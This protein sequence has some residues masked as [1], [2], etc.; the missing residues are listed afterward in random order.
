MVNRYKISLLGALLMF[1]CLV[2]PAQKKQGYHAINSGIPWFDGKGNAISAHGANIIMDKGRYY[3]FGEYKSDTSNAFNGFSC[4]SS[5]DLCN[6]KFENMAL[7][8]QDTGKLG[9][10]RVGERVKILKCPATG[11]YVMFMHADDMGYKDQ[12]IG[13]ATCNTINGTYKFRGPLL[14]DGK[15]IKKWDMGVFQ[16]TDGSGYVIT[17]SGNLYKLSGDYKSVT[18][19]VVKDMTQQCEAP[20]IFK[21]SGVYFWLGSDLTSWE[22]NDNYYFTAT[23]LKGPWTP[24]GN[25]A[26]RGTLT[27]NSQT[28]YVLTIAGAEDTTYMYMGDRWAFPHQNS[29]ATYV[30]QPLIVKGTTLSLPGF[31]Q[32]W[33]VDPSTG[34]WI[35]SSIKGKAIA[36]TDT[37]SIQYSGKWIH[38]PK[39]DSLSD[40]RS[41]TRGASFSVSFTGTQIGFYGVAGKD[42][43]YARVKI[44]DN[45]GKTV[46]SSL[47]DMYCNYTECSLKFLSPVLEKGKYTLS[48]TVTGEHGNWSDKKKNT[49]GSTG[50][51]ISVNKVLIQN[52]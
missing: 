22:R 44:Q 20:A 37:K 18:E 51:F 40:S 19:Q 13:Y 17:H 38:S 36:H 27:F 39:T 16:D 31:R 35:L 30:W 8:V 21:K 50:N 47:V 4:Y 26:P 3:L 33:Q 29:A 24:R 11:E 1:S 23:S 25:F 14:F 28:T 32:S 5:A 42:G 48:V 45:K 46:L 12:F 49:F 52:Q 10:G 2:A 9:P 34:K 43:G 15:P 7:P 41:D 6:W